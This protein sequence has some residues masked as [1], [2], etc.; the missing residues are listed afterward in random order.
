M[1]IDSG[2]ALLLILALIRAGMGEISTSANCVKLRSRDPV[3]KGPLTGASEGPG[4][5]MPDR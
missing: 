1:E 4:F 5:R 2:A 3:V